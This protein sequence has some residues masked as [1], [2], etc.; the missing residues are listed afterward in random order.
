MNIEAAVMPEIK[1]NRDQSKSIHLGT[2]RYIVH[3]PLKG[4]IYTR[5]QQEAHGVIASRQVIK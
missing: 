3:P 2:A 4:Y 1:I 5:R